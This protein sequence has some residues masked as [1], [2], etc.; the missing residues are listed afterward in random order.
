MSGGITPDMAIDLGYSVLRNY[1]ENEVNYTLS[2]NTFEIVNRKLNGAKTVSGGKGFQ[3]DV[4]L[5]DTGNEKFV[6]D[7]ETD[8]PNVANVIQECTLNWT[9]FQ[10]SWSYS[11][12]ELNEC[13]GKRK[14]FDLL[15]TRRKGCV[16]ESAEA[17]DQIMWRPPLSSTDKRRPHGIAS[18]IV[19]ADADTCTGDW[20][21]YVG[22]Y[23]SDTETA[24]SKV[25]GL[26]CTS[27][28]NAR[29]ANWYYDHNDNLDYT[30]LKK[31]S[32]ALR[33]THFQT[34]RIAGDS[35]DPKSDFSNFQ[36]YTNDE[37][38]ATLEDLAIKADDRVGPNLGKYA[39]AVTFKNMPLIYIDDLDT[40]KTYVWGGNPIYGINWNQV[41][42]RTLAGETFRW[43]KPQNDVR[44]H[45]VYTVYLD[46]TFVLFCTNR[47]H[48]GFLM[49][50][51]EASN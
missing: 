18:W 34:P 50:D 4:K 39:G 10:N 11:L 16:V 35:L 38:I 42:I 1:D 21:G 14:I 6:L 20:L 24:F 41:Q 47:R 2:K 25:G 44:Q 13:A 30:L 36:L 3:W 23:W 15:T 22:D 32:T 5:K 17:L 46:L 31:M 48:A 33:K 8:D 28:V 37:V 12:L 40:D 43:N 19:Q 9:S 45:N 26:S 27:T 49:S 51:W 29:W 7:Y